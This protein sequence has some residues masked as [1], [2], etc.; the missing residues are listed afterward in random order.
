MH[1]ITVPGYTNSGPEHWQTRLEQK[2]PQI[3]RVQQQDWA[4]PAR[5]A[6][7][8]GITATLA[9]L[10]GEVV[11]IGHSCGAVAITQ[12]AAQCRMR[13]MPTLN[14]KGALL[15][16]PADVDA[17]D[18]LEAIRVQR[19]LSLEALPFPSVLVASDNDEHLSLTRAN[20]LAAA[21]GSELRI[22]RGGG[23]L[24]SAAG[25][26]EWPLSEVLINQISGNQLQPV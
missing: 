13:D 14:I 22:I 1:F 21:W 25:Y 6:W 17:P 24:H 23:H 18:A 26:G 5:Q 7:I 15:V 9:P 3:I 10:R 2:Y 20:Q 16:A 12:W 8:D 19:P 4:C 11:L